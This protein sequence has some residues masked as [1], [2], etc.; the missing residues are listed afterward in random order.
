MYVQNIPGEQLKLL[1]QYVYLPDMFWSIIGFIIQRSHGTAFMVIG[2][3]LH[4]SAGGFYLLI[5]L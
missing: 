2:Q 5:R 1:K 4:H 3:K